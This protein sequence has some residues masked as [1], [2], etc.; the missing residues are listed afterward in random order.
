MPDSGA[1]VRIHSDDPQLDAHSL[2]TALEDSSLDRSAPEIRI[3]GTEVLAYL[4]EADLEHIDLEE[5]QT[6]LQSE[7]MQLRVDYCGADP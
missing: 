6:R 1:V 5:A 7:G 2:R 3:E 4:S